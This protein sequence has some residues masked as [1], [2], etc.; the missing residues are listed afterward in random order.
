L[1]LARKEDQEKHVQELS[2]LKRAIH[3]LKQKTCDAI[4][5]REKE[6]D[7]MQLQMQVER[8]ALEHEVG[9]LVLTVKEQSAILEQ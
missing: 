1:E 4:D 7:E 3:A 2:H 8:T 9:Q 6:L 5:R